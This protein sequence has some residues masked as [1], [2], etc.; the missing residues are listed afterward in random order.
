MKVKL[1]DLVDLQNEATAVNRI[2]SNSQ[3]IELGFDNTLSRDGTIPN[4]MNAELDM[5]SNHIIN[6]PA[7]ASSEE[8]IR[9]GDLTNLSIAGLL[10]IPTGTI[11]GNYSGVTSIP[12]PQYFSLSDTN[13]FETRAAVALQSISVTI[14]RIKV[15][16]YAVG[17]PLYNTVYIQG[18]S[19]GPGAIQSLNGIWWNIDLSSGSA[20]AESFG[21]KGDFS[22]DDAPA[23][24]ATI[25]A[26][27]ANG[28]GTLIPLPNK[29]Y[30]LGS[31]STNGLSCVILR[32]KV[33]IMGNGTSVYKLKAG[34]NQPLQFWFLFYSATAVN[35]VI[36]SGFTCDFN[37]SL[38]TGGNASALNLAISLDYGDNIIVDRIAV[39]NNPG[40]VSLGFGRN[41]VTPTV[42]N[43][44]ITNCSCLNSG[45][46]VNPGCGDHSSI[47][48]I[49]ANCVIAHNTLRLGGH[50]HSTGIE[51]HG[52]GVIV[53]GN[54]ISDYSGGINIAN[55]LESP[56]Y[57]IS[58]IANTL[59][60]V[61]YGVGVFARAFQDLGAIV[62]ANNNIA[63][64]PLNPS[65]GIDAASAISVGSNALNITITNNII[66]SY[67]MVTSASSTYTGISLG[68]FT[69][70]NCTGNQIFNT[71]GPG[72]W[73]T[74]V[75]RPGSIIN[76]SDNLLYN[77]GMGTFDAL[78]RAGVKVDTN[79][80]AP[81]SLNIRGNCIVAGVGYNYGILGSLNVTSG[82]IISNAIVGA[83]IANIS[84]TGTGMSVGV[85]STS[86]PTTA[87][88]TTVNGSVIRI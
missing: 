8:P 36:Y 31:L 43:L 18:T 69:S 80:N 58:A 65:I 24:R 68:G 49:A 25:D 64:D 73:R 61:R 45:D 85:T 71:Q 87:N 7:P 34:V 84:Y 20:T 5:N 51:A 32:N 57:Q 46:N 10:A 28:G 62:I 9:L 88:F 81:G 19:T 33:N 53:I 38:N 63:I 67:G 15:A 2:N 1:T 39:I 3:A 82:Q 77:P 42:T 41:V 12:T 44:R 40:S 16:R 4:H 29:T 6:L 76:I 22:V 55:E 30:Q 66:T 59:T 75:C 74:G 60:N 50:L 56:S 11:L 14:P 23:I 17:Y 47:H 21:A 26:L 72:I 78:L 48:V 52:T 37:G 54:T 86:T 35:D 13:Q 70:V 27:F 79:A 83:I